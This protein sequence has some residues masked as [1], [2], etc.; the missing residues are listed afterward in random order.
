MVKKKLMSN[1]KGLLEPLYQ[2]SSSQSNRQALPSEIHFNFRV[3]FL[4]RTV[5]DYLEL[6]ATTTKMYSWAPS[7]FNTDETICRILHSQ[8]RCAPLEEEYAPSIL[9][10]Y[11][12]FKHHAKATSH[13]PALQ[14]LEAEFE[15][16]MSEYPIDQTSDDKAPVLMNDQSNQ[17][18]SSTVAGTNASPAC[19]STPS[20]KER[21]PFKKLY[22]KV[23]EPGF[24]EECK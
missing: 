7:G 23:M 16:I 2:S 8:L 5:R 6:L 10:L 15:S 9:S 14:D 13:P 20:E 3:E 4:H 22:K 24:H 19:T 21:I 17:G 12:V 11:K 1:C 18:T